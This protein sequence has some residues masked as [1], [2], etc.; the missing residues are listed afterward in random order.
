MQAWQLQHMYT[1]AKQ[2]HLTVSSQR[3]HCYHDITSTLLTSWYL[4]LQHTCIQF[5]QIRMTVSSKKHHSRDSGVSSTPLESVLIYAG[6][7]VAAYVQ[8]ARNSA[9]GC[10]LTEASLLQWCQ[11]HLPKAAVPGSI[12]LL[13]QL[14]RGPAGKLSRSVLPPPAWTKAPCDAHGTQQYCH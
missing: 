9:S 11:E 7:A 3:H 6:L 13:E 4:Q 5:K 2:M 14:P 1:Q 8:P 10:H 12:Q